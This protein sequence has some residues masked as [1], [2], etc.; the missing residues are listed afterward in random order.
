MRYLS[1]LLV[2][3]IFAQQSETTSRLPDLNGGYTTEGQTFAATKSSTGS[4]RVELAPSVNGSLVP[5]ETVKEKILRDDASG[6]VIE[7]YVQRHDPNGNP[8][9]VEKTVI[10]E[11]KSGGT[12]TVNTTVYRGDLN[13]NLQA[14]ERSVSQTVKQGAVTNTETTIERKGLDGQFIPAERIQATTI[15][16]SKTQQTQTVTRLRR[17]PSGNFY[18]AVKETST[19]ETTA[20]GQTVENRAQYVDGALAEQAVA[21]TVTGPDGAISTT[22][23]LYSTQAPGLS[24]DIGGKLALKERQQVTR[25]PGPGGQITETVISRKPTTDANRLGP[26]QVV[27]KTVCQG[28]CKQP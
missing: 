20:D 4:S 3:P 18:E 14:S 10:E 5:R 9:P 1:I 16:Q 15:E 6:R 28:D 12:V 27:S 7:R 17:D 23:D 25:Q 21:R 8:G 2:F 19:R 22:V 11:K 24:A 26:A 13:G